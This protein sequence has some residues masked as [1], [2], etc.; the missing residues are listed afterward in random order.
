MAKEPIWTKGR[1]KSLRLRLGLTQKEFGEVF[2]L[3]MRT[4]Q[5]WELGNRKPSASSRKL[6]NIV[7]NKGHLPPSAEV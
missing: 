6:L 2:G 5:D 4:V 1:I 3:A 7:N